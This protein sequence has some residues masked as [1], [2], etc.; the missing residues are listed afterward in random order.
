MHYQ[1][2]FTVSE[3]TESSARVFLEFPTEAGNRSLTGKLVGPHCEY[4]RTLP[5]EFSF[6]EFSPPDIGIFSDLNRPKYTTQV[7]DPCYWTPELPFLYDLQVSLQMENGQNVE[8]QAKIGLTRWECHWRNLRLESRRIVLRGASI[9]QP[10]TDSI[11]AARAANT[12]L[13]VDRYDRTFCDVAD[14]IGVIVCLDLRTAGDS[15]R[16]ILSQINSSTSV[17]LVLISSDQ[18]RQKNLDN[19]WPSNCIVAEFLSTTSPEDYTDLGTVVA[20]ELRGEERP[21]SWIAKAPRPVIV[22]RRGED[23]A[24]LTAARAACDRL[25]A[26][27][28]PEFDLAGYFVA[29]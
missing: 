22:I 26:E 24:D 25:Q 13:L 9:E 2:Q 21:P 3:Q 4:A 19:L 14:Q 28:A 20:F 6:A 10:S 12:A 18:R 23:Y 11:P 17:F 1:F 27:L 29:P 7:I 16:S 8:Y 15:L 5:A